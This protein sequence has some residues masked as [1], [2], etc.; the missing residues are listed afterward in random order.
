MNCEVNVDILQM[1]VRFSVFSWTT[2]LTTV[3]QYYPHI[4]LST[5]TISQRYKSILFTRERR[6]RKA[7]YRAG[8]ETRRRE[9]TGY[10]EDEVFCGERGQC[11]NHSCEVVQVC[12]LLWQRRYIT[13]SKHLCYCRPLL[14]GSYYHRLDI[15][16]YITIH[17]KDVLSSQYRKKL[18]R[19]RIYSVE[20]CRER[21]R[22]RGPNPKIRI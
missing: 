3:A 2:P 7:R 4:P 12:L 9:D 20:S 22:E 18:S 21:E 15:K 19:I 10:D 5:I 8:R 13:S 11:R 1:N 16:V 17:S 6:P 14:L